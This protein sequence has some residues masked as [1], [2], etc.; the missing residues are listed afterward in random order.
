M[1]NIFFKTVFFVIIFFLGSINPLPAQDAFEI[2]TQA[3]QHFQA[4]NYSEMTKLIEKNK[5]QLENSEIYTNL[6]YILGVAYTNMGDYP[7]A[8]M[9]YSE[10][11]NIHEKTLGKEHQSYLNALTNL[12]YIYRMM[13]DYYKAET[14]YQEVKTI[15]ENVFGKRDSGYASSV[16]SLADLYFDMGDFEKAKTFYLESINIQIDKDNISYATTLNNLAAVYC[17]L[18]DFANAET[19]YRDAIPLLEKL[20]GKENPNYAF[21]LGNLG[22]VY[23][24]QG[25][26]LKAEAYYKDAKTLQEYVLG[27]QHPAY[28]ISINNLGNLYKDIGE[29]DKAEVL[30]QEEK[31]IWENGFGKENYNHIRSLNALG[32]LYLTTKNYNSAIAEKCKADMIVTKQIE[33]NFTI[34]SERQRAL[35]WDKNKD[36]LEQ[37][38]SYVYLHPI[39]NMTSHAYDNTLFTKGLLLRTANGIRDVVYHSGDN[40]LISQYEEL[41]NIFQTINILQAKTPPDFQTIAKLENS[42]DSLDKKITISSAAYSEIKKDISMNWQ[43]VRNL[44]Q[45][46]EAAVEYVHFRLYDGKGFTGNTIYCAMILKKDALAPVWIPLCDEQQLQSLTRRSSY[47]IVKHTQQLYSGVKGDSLYRLIWQ[48]LEKE[49]QGVRTV[50]Y[51]PSGMLHQ[52]AFAAVPAG[53]GNREGGNREGLPLLSD[54]YDLRLVSSTREIARLKKE[55]SGTLPQ[56]T[57][58]IFGGLYYDADKDRLIAEAQKAASPHSPPNPHSSPS[59]TLQRG[60]VS[61]DFLEGTEIEA[62]QICEYLEERKIPYR[63]YSG[64]EGNEEAFK[65]LSGA[66]AGVIHLATHGFFLEDLE[67][68]YQREIVEQLNGGRGKPLENPLLRSGLLLAGANRAWTGEDVIKEIE[69]GILIADEIAQMNLIKTKLVVLSA[70]ETGLGEAKTSEGVFGLQRAFK[71]SGVETLIMSLWTVPDDATAELMTAFYQLWLSGKTKREAF[72]TSQKQVREKYKEPFHWA[73]FVMMD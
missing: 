68:E 63:L 73:G 38:Y 48:P 18:N 56:G 29:Y 30:F 65:R 26:Y 39:N 3:M 50:Y 58:A 7:K 64:T 72:D 46:G 37:C 43:D 23:R 9:A 52:I 42:A 33:K 32:A 51:S 57:A 6:L 15:R 61:W 44:L 69:D 28:A 12:G 66:S 71:L 34:L 40:I 62:E 25:D 27:K 22:T 31:A 2:L 17:V 4:G 70:C 35:F 16:N 20:L 1:K 36:L 49:L 60:G 67:N 19:C 21:T 41:K 8:E 59:L 45:S 53:E 11:K 5:T 54:K 47:D 13:G 14:C 24:Y 55:T 10:E